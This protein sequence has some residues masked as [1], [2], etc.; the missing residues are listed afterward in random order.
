MPYFFVFVVG[1]GGGV[2]VGFVC[3]TPTTPTTPSIPDTPATASIYEGFKFCS[4][5]YCVGMLAQ[6]K[7]V[8]RATYA[9]W[10][11]RSFRTS[12]AVHQLWF[13]AQ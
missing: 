8:N 6:K 5:L 10:A 12:H 1:G 2:Y 7:Y 9:Q 11:V 13:M 4:W 3:T